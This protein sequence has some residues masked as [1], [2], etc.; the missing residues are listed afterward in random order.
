[1]IV[2][3]SPE[4]LSRYCYFTGKVYIF[5]YVSVSIFAFHVLYRELLIGEYLLLILYM[6]AFSFTQRL[7]ARILAAVAVFT[8]VTGLVPIQAFAD[9]NLETSLVEVNP[10][11]TI[12]H[13]NNGEN[14]FSHQTVNAKSIVNLP[15]GHNKHNDGGLDEKGDI[16]PSFTYNFGEGDMTYH[17][18]NLDTLYITG[19]TGQ[20]ILD[21]EC[22][23]QGGGVCLNGNTS[24]FCG[25]EAQIEV[26]KF[27]GLDVQIP[28]A[29]WKITVSNHDDVNI[30]LTTDIDGCVSTSVD[31][32]KGPYYAAE[33][34][35][36]GWTQ[37]FVTVSPNLSLTG[38]VEGNEG[39]HICKMNFILSGNVKNSVANPAEY[40]CTF[41]NS[42]DEIVPPPTCSDGIINQDETGIDIG[43]VCTPPTECPEGQVLVDGT[44]Q[45]P[46]NPQLCTVEI[47][48]DTSATVKEKGAFAK[49][50]TFIHSAWTATIPGAT[51]IWGDDP[52][53]DPTI[54][55][56]QT[57]ENKFGFLGTVTSATLE[58][59][60][61]ND[62]SA[63][64]NGNT[65][66]NGGSTFAAATS[67]D[68]T[69]EILQGNN[70]LDI[71]VTNLAV[72]GS[73][74]TA[75]PA[76]VKYKL[77]IR[78]V[79]DAGDEDCAVPY[80]NE[81][82]EP[83]D[84]QNTY[85]IY[86]YVWHDDNRNETWDGRTDEE[87][88]NQE[89]VL[90][91]WTVKI[92][93]GTDTFTTATDENGYYYFDVPAGTWTITESDVPDHWF[94]TTAE[95]YTVTVPGETAMN[96]FDAFVNF[97]IPTAYAAAA[98]ADFGEYNFGNDRRSGG[99]GGGTRTTPDDDDDGAGQVL[100][101]TD[102]APVGEVLGEQV[103][104]VPTGAPNAGA[105]GTSP[106]AQNF[107]GIVPV[108]FIRR[109][110]HV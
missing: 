10:D 51:W 49:V 29:N 59:A 81:Q 97:F 1:M 85:R 34:I 62:H 23:N 27:I 93:N 7:S 57:F 37:N 38:S 72:T 107:Y 15:N 36:A 2:V 108:A 80:K 24:P 18:K 100:G 86:G 88:N 60:S 87:S 25:V 53:A 5:L 20:Q 61:D 43:G 4:K 90:A 13:A 33:E 110:L 69:S 26:C 35:R 68:V 66:H 28:L 48:S 45:S 78:G 94:N 55:E 76:G 91:G 58:V 12:C 105:G 46:E 104:A 30:E 65:A 77:T 42:Q 95:S 98:I 71:A 82:E 41:V 14:F 63:V 47:V 22:V 103:S 39:A 6:N 75:N 16:I 67:Y 84:N 99:G 70:L 9:P 50:L 101:A 52:V 73:D 44:C 11:V 54:E 40:N 109:K 106:F 102:D 31:A 21:D 79:A 64:V 32:E 8:L 89:E 17:G 74:Y 3:N 83:T 96:T 56:T 92:T 19:L